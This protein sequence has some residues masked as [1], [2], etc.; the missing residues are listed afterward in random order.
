VDEAV[1]EVQEEV[2]PHRGDDTLH[3]HAVVEDAV[4]HGQVDPVVVQRPGFDARRRGAERGAATAAGAILAVGD[5]EEDELLGGDG[6]DPAVVDG[7]AP[8]RGSLED[9]AAQGGP[10]AALLVPAV[11]EF[12]ARP[13]RARPFPP[14]LAAGVTPAVLYLAVAAGWL[15]WLGPWEGPAPT[16][17]RAGP[18]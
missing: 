10:A 9:I 8:A 4:E 13:G 15:L 17:P 5:V 16:T 18:R 11:V 12:A 6:A 2:P 14:V 7:W 1:G 3:A